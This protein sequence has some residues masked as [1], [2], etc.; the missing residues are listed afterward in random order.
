MID[1]NH[2][3]YDWQKEKDNYPSIA[4]RLKEINEKVNKIIDRDTFI[5]IKWKPGVVKNVIRF[6]AF[7]SF[8]KYSNLISIVSISQIP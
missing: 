4:K 3:R 7:P 8:I 6:L 1:V 5:T 2:V